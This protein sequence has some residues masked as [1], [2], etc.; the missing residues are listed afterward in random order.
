MKFTSCA[1]K[2]IHCC[3]IE[4]AGGVFQDAAGILYFANKTEA[5]HKQT[6]S[7]M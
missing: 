5:I 7:I 1:K 4:N 2:G 3:D 6:T